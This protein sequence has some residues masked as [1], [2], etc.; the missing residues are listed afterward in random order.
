MQGKQLY[1][2][3]EIAED[4]IH[5]LV[6]EYYMSRFN[7]LRSDCI[8]I[9]QAINNK[10]IEKPQVVNATITKLLNNA[11]KAL[12]LKIK[13]VILCIPSVDVKCVKKRVN[14]AIEE[15]SRKILMS[16]VRNG[17]EKAVSYEKDSEYEFVNVG[18]IKYIVGGISS[19]TIPLDERSDLLTM[20]I[21]MLYA[22]KEIVYSYVMCVEACGVSVLDICLDSFAMAEESATLENS[23]DK[24]VVLADLQKNDTILS[25]YYKGRLLE[26]ERLGRGYQSWINELHRRHRL[27][28]SEAEAM[29]LENCFEEK[30][31]YD[32]IVSYIWMDRDEQKQLTKK[33]IFETVSERVESWLNA[34]NEMCEPIKD[35]GNSKF[36]VSGKGADIVGIGSVLKALILP[37]QV[38]VPS[39]IGVR[40]G[41]Y[42]ACLGAMYC[43]KKWQEIKNI[44]DVSI[45]YN[46]MI[47]REVK[48]EDD[49]GF[50][51]KLKNILQVK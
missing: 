50:T 32:D 19:R 39:N 49:A 40:E 33:Q 7:I 6:G 28:V 30:G 51:K 26:C 18:S 46:N 12:S 24:Y 36:I 41:K 20:D 13:K 10:K 25:L 45:E 43:T 9:N 4:E 34:I 35:Y 1:A 14:V 31:I 29:L 11:E 27:S 48:R 22:N 15:G 44:K 17:L 42:S 8:K 38:Y 47:A 23:M 21:D 37:S 16:H 3:L 5:L 2:S